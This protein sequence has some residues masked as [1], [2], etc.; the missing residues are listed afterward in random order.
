LKPYLGVVSA[1]CRLKTPMEVAQFVLEETE[2]SNDRRSDQWK[3]AQRNQAN[4][5]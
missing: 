2:V 5:K 3:M 1:P 4:N